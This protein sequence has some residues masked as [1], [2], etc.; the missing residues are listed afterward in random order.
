ML[1]YSMTCLTIL[2]FQ[3]CGNSLGNALSC[4]RMTMPPCT[5]RGPYRNG[6]SS[7]VWKNLDGLHRDLTSTLPNTFG[8]KWTAD[9]EPGLIAQHQCP[10]SLMLLWL[11]GS[12]SPRDVPTSIGM[13]S[14]KSGGCYGIKARTYS[15]LMLIILQ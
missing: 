11:H 7:S 9:C 2:C 15:L 14:Q 4:F 6:L 3:L 12:K 1:Q 8:M 13:P 10:T 5:K